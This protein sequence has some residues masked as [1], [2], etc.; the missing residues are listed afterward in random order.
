[1][2]DRLHGTIEDIRK[3]FEPVKEK[4]HNAGLAAPFYRQS[5][6]TASQADVLKNRVQVGMWDAEMIR[7]QAE[8]DKYQRLCQEAD[9]ALKIGNPADT[10]SIRE[11]ATQR[12]QRL[13]ELEGNLQ[14]LK[15]QRDILD[16][17]VRDQ[18]AYVFRFELLD[19]L[20]SGRA[21]V[22]PRTMANALA[23]LPTMRW[24]QSLSRC[25]R[26][27]FD[28]PRLEYSVFELLSEV[29]G[30]RSK[31][32]K[33]APVD[34]FQS[35]LLKLSEKRVYPRQFLWD[36]WRDLKNAIDECWKS[37]RPLGSVPFVL[38]STFMR[39]VTRQKDAAERI[40][41]ERERLH[42]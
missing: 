27:P 21:A 25:S 32:F 39:Y 30:H 3:I 16:L 18:E 6:Q 12:Q 8:R 41:A 28:P 20:L 5:A 37:T 38:T 42:D 40:L 1:M 14:K 24:R 22:D 17:K 13:L 2:R 33:V 10:E 7:I 23:G 9:A 11:V 15:S 29:W 34:F 19:F 4:Q 35:E 31:E 36:N 26:M